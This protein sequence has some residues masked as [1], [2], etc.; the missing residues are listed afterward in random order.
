MVGER[1]MGAVRSYSK[2]KL[3]RRLSKVRGRRE[4][5]GGGRVKD[6]EAPGLSGI[7]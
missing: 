2:R 6:R 4:R 5:V 3:R 1:E 7:G